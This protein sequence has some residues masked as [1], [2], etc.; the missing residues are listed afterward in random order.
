[1]SFA[2]A[3]APIV[4]AA[5]S[6]A[7]LAAEIVAAASDGS[8]KSRAARFSHRR[9]WNSGRRVFRRALLRW[10]VDGRSVRCGR[11]ACGRLAQTV[12]AISA[13]RLSGT[14]CLRSLACVWEDCARSRRRGVSYALRTIRAKCALAGRIHLDRGRIS[15]QSV[16]MRSLVRLFG[17][18]FPAALIACQPPGPD[19]PHTTLNSRAD[20]LRAAF[21][22]DSGMVRVVMLAS[23]T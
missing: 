4:R 17:I 11:R 2:V 7:A 1:M 18:A 8:K 6:P 20:E 23:P 10:T 9:H 13:S 21:N 15:F 22:A 16:G 19:R 3:N 12:P 5:V 14:D